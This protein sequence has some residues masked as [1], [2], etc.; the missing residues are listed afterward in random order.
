MRRSRSFSTRT[1]LRAARSISVWARSTDRAEAFAAD[2]RSRGIVALAAHDLEAA[3][4][5]ADIVTCA[6]L[7]NAPLIHG[8]WLGA[9]SH[10]DLIGGFTPSMREADDDCFAGV[11]LYVDTEEALQKS[12]DLLEPMKRGVF[13]ASD[14]RGT[15]AVLARGEA[16]GRRSREERTVCRP[17][18][19]PA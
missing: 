4:R 3:T 7:A 9:G 15:L 5:E 19:A 10:L 16:A 8:K 14:V 1:G 17:T 13:G 18:R 11:A 2:L 6:T 12:G